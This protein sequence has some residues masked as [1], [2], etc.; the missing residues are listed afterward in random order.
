[1][2]IF[3]YIYT[4]RNDYVAWK[5]PELKEMRWLPF[6]CCVFMCACDGFG[7]GIL[8]GSSKYWPKPIVSTVW[9]INY[10]A[11]IYGSTLWSCANMTNVYFDAEKNGNRISPIT[12][13]SQMSTLG[14]MRGFDHALQRNM[15]IQAR[16][17]W[18]LRNMRSWPKMLCLTELLDTSRAKRRFFAIQDWNFA[19]GNWGVGTSWP[20]KKG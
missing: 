7:V 4:Y 1:M 14:S 6:F 16:E 20:S 2:I 19:Q 5:S 9:T 15:E 13:Q 12:R 3:I 10:V 8:G 17:S 18:D 11:M